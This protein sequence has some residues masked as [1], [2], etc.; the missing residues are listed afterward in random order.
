MV[1]EAAP[2]P[3]REREKRKANLSGIDE[4]MASDPQDLVDS[5]L[6]AGFLLGFVES[7]FRRISFR[8]SSN[9]PFSIF[10]T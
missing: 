2:A 7:S 3:A 10:Y 5:D 9:T 1:K 8:A 6:C 4:L